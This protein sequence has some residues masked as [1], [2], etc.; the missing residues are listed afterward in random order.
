MPPPTLNSEEPPNGIHHFIRQSG[1]GV[2]RPLLS[3]FVDV[4]LSASVLSVCSSSA[5]T[6]VAPLLWFTASHRSRLSKGNGLMQEVKLALVSSEYSLGSCGWY[7][8]C[9]EC[10]R[11]AR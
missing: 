3:S 8:H 7:F 10:D 1:M 4:L 9:V 6:M 5:G 2:R 11:W